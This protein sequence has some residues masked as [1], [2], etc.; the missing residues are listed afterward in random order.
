MSA[1]PSDTWLRRVHALLAKAESTEFPA[2][3]E[4]LLAKAQELMARHAIDEAMLT[5]AHGTGPGEIV[6]ETVVVPP[7]YAAPKASLLCRVAEANGCR[8][9]IARTAVAGPQRCVVVGH[10]SNVDGAATLFAALSMHA[11]RTMLAAVV[12]AHDTPRRFRHAFLLHFAARIGERLH[13]AAH[14][15]RAQVEE[16]GGSTVAVVLADRSHAVDRAVAAQFPHLR[17]VRSQSSS[18]AGAQR[19][20]AAAD[21]AALGQSG[22]RSTPSLHAG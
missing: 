18:I 10:R 16:A 9:V 5:A 4:T 11:T 1:T 8:A 15:A 3:A 12:P 17:F 6:S 14:A 19:G 22:L 21:Q 20:R 13:E 7:P 2:E